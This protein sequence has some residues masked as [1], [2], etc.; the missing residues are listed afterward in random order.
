MSVLSSRQTW[1][2][3]I[4]LRL[5]LQSQLLKVLVRSADL[6]Y[7]QPETTSTKQGKA[8]DVHKYYTE[9]EGT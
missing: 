7:G 1:K 4:N 5:T 9:P 6:K 8:L 2:V 3:I